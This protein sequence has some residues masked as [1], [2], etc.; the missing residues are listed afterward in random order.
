MKLKW[1]VVATMATIGSTAYAESSVTLFG[2]LDSGLLYQ[3]TSAAS[4]NPA[5]KN[6]GRLYTLKDGGIYSS[7]W[8]LKGTE[9]IGGGYSVNFRLQGAFTSTSGALR[10]SDTP[11]VSA[12]FNQESSVGVSGPFGSINA[13]RQFAPMAY[14]LAET[15]VRG[16]QYFGSILTSWLGMNQSAGW[17]G[18][19]T[20]GPI[21]ALYDSNAIVYNSPKFAGVS[22]A[23][24]YAPGGVAGSIQGGTRESAVLKYSNY[25]LSLA[26]IYYNGHDSNPGTTVPTGRDNNRFMY[27]GGEYTTHGFSVSASYANGRD[28]SRSNV[29]DLDMISGGLGYRFTPAFR[30]T[31][32]IYYLKDANNSANKSL[33]FAVGVDYSLSKA[34]TL[35]AQAGHVNNEGTMTTTLTY[36]APVAPHSATT[37]V[38]LGIRHTF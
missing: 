29:V 30:V 5:G 14:A 33:E 23:L 24:E 6:L 16:G 13:G 12:M 26:A 10:L 32:G 35:Y 36:G 38:N 9:D 31:S 20:N 15:D 18:T 4:F 34:T 22:V 11:G 1:F 17:V 25:G 37:A 2:V 7:L 27:A 19:S 3:S 21:G 28:P 8:G